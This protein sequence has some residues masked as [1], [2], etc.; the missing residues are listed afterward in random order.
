MDGLLQDLRFAGR[1]IRRRW[2]TSLVIVLILGLGIAV[3]TTVFTNY[4]GAELRPLPFDEPDRLK[5]LMTTFPELGIENSS[6]SPLDVADLRAGS[7]RLGALGEFTYE[8]LDF[9][10]TSVGAA[11]NAERVEASRISVDLFQT[12]G[13]K[14]MLGRSFTA[15]EGLPGGARVAI[16]GHDFWLRH[17]QGDPSVVGS[18]LRLDD[19]VHEVVGVMP[20]GFGFPVWHELWVPLALEPTDYPRDRRFVGLLTRL[21]HGV[22]PA[23][24]QEELDAIA[25]RLATTYPETNEGRGFVIRPLRTLWMPPAA[26]ALQ[27]AQLGSVMFVLLIVCANIA[28]LVLAQT[29]S[30]HR[31]TALRSAL[32]ASRSRLTRQLLTESSLLA[33]V[34][35]GLGILMSVWGV[36][37]MM[38][39]IP[40]SLPFWLRFDLEPVI[41]LYALVI[42][43]L[44]VIFFGAMPALRHAGVDVFEALR[45]GGRDGAG[46]DTNRLRRV[47]VVGELSMSVVL[48]VGAL[49]MVQ[50]FLNLHYQDKGYTSDGIATLRLS[51]ERES[52]AENESRQAYLQRATEELAALPGVRFLGAT[53][54]L[55]SSG[56][57]FGTRFVRREIEAEGRP[58]DE[59]RDWPTT[60]VVGVGEGYLETLGIPLLRGRSFLPAEMASPPAEGADGAVLVSRGLAERLWP[61]ESALGRRLRPR[62][63]EEGWWRVVGVVDDVAAPYQLVNPS[64]VPGDQLYRPLVASVPGEVSFALAIDGQEMASVFPALRQTLQGVDARVPLFELMTLDRML[65]RV[66]W[67]P[68]WMGEMFSIFAI[69][70]L[71]IAAIGVY[72]VHAYAVSQQR[73]EMG[74][75]LALGARPGE[76]AGRVVW[77]GVKQGLLGL[78]IGLA[79]ALPMSMGLSMLLLEVRAGDPRIF[80]SVALILL[81][82]TAL[83]CWQPARRAART[84]PMATL[85]EE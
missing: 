11:G 28:N 26:S 5:V 16:L 48:L 75:R 17:F 52:Y 37:W 71:V 7:E 19:V 68:R 38:Q 18:T 56:D 50:S 10:P 78:V 81:V 47:L 60:N 76:L 67:I 69:L 25:A 20:E 36:E 39:R 46:R 27:I 3:N 61:G 13:V 23:R 80:G 8:V 6:F 29:S 35:G 84:D 15:E 44:S 45:G 54:H 32:G 79:L 1:L 83:A 66:G 85:R 14:P 21:D 34:G 55:P 64:A 63:E 77:G 42:S 58:L 30:R 2:G 22:D 70:A 65:A 59:R 12:L 72:G 33:L 82:T 74:I 31:E 62:D 73:R 40:V 9:E 24:A 43:A 57:G 4:Y 53:S 49:L 51:L 41:L